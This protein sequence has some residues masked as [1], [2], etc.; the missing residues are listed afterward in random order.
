MSFPYHNF[1]AWSET[2]AHAACPCQKS[3][4]VA[5]SMSYAGDGVTHCYE[6]DL[7][8]S[9][10]LGEA[11]ARKPFSLSLSCTEL[12]SRLHLEYRLEKAA[13]SGAR[14]KPRMMRFLRGTVAAPAAVREGRSRI[15]V[16]R[17]YFSGEDSLA[18]N[19]AGAFLL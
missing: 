17:P 18:S 19:K 5:E 3:R 6:V 10:S 15:E 2:L 8:S 13:A 9:Q 11:Q 12:S 16:H 1:S 14:E 4:A 7:K